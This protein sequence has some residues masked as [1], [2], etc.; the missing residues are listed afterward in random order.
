[1][2]ATSSVSVFASSPDHYTFLTSALDTDPDFGVS[3]LDYQ[4]DV[5]D[6]SGALIGSVPAQSFIYQSQQKY[7]VVPNIAISQPIDHATLEITNAAWI[8][9]STLGVIPQ[10]VL[11]NTQVSMSSSTVTVSGQLTNANLGSFEKVI[12]VTIF[13]NGNANSPIGASQTELDNVQAQSTANFSITY[14]AVTGI[15]PTSNQVIVYGIR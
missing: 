10:F 5:Y 9:S 2:I 8:A 6:T 7:L 14:P 3:S 4:I 11:Q 1:M 15:N 12:V 13:N